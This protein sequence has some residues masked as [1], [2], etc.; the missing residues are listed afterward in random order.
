[1]NPPARCASLNGH[2]RQGLVRYE[3]AAA[4]DGTGLVLRPGSLLVEFVQSGDPTAKILSVGKLQD[5]QGHSASAFAKV[6]HLPG[7]VL[8]PAFVNAHTHLDLTHI[9]PQPHD[10]SEGFVRWVDMIRTRRHL[11]SERIAESV[12]RGIELSL[13]AGVVAVGDIA[14]APGG[15]PSLAPHGALRDSVLRGVSYLEFFGIGTIRDRSR[16]S[17]EA[18]LGKV[19]E[20]GE[21]R[22]R[23]GLQPH[24]PSSVDLRVYEWAAAAASLRGMMI[25]THLAETPEERDFVANARGPQRNFL[26]KLG[27]WDD[28]VLE[29]IGHGKHPVRHLREV[30][31]RA[32]FTVAHVNDADDAAIA[33]LAQTQ[34]SVAYCPRAS[35]YFGAEE[36]FGPHRYQDMLKAGINVALG[37]DSIV[38]LPPEAATT[39]GLSVLDEMRRLSRRDGT[40]PKTLL[41]MGTLNGA[42][43]LGMDSALFRFQVGGTIAGIAAAPQAS[44][45]EEEHP[46]AGCLASKDPS[47]LM[48]ENV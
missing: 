7:S 48:M 43:A 3:A 22:V 10:A 41:R 2:S 30:L 15:T 40:D 20:N 46:F 6:V 28:S 21:D 11:S 45:S 14:G 25:A 36:H 5:V 23:F 31:S 32:R 34:T 1:M 33:I 35:E 17:V 44:Q 4:C 19:S 42:A 13:A 16:E 39:H 9:G 18:V 12:R 29:H 26:E 37:T 27:I 47:I 24:A 8:V 38:N